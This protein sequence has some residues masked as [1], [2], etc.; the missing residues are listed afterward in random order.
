MKN[1]IRNTALSLA[2]A[3]VCAVPVMAITANNTAT[4]NTITAS[5]EATFHEQVIAGI[6]YKCFNDD[7]AFV[8][9][10]DTDL[11]IAR[12]PQ[13]IYDGSRFYWVE[14]ISAYAFK[15][16]KALTAIDLSHAA[17]LTTIQAGAFKGASNLRSVTL[18]PAVTS[19]EYEAFMDCSS[20]ESFDLNGSSLPYI[21][22]R[23]FKGCSSLSQFDLPGSVSFIGPEAFAESGI[24]EIDVKGN[25]SCIREGAFRNCRQLKKLTIEPSQTPISLRSEAFKD[26]VNL[27]LADLDR[28]DT[29]T[30]IDVFYGCNPRTLP[31]DGLIM[32]GRGIPSFTRS[33]CEKLLKLWDIHYDPNATDEEKRAVLHELGT[34][35]RAYAVYDNNG[36]RDL[37]CAPTVLSTRIS[38]CGGFTRSFY[39][40]AVTMGFDPDDILIG[41]DGHCHGWN[42]VRFD[43]KW[44]SYDI[45]NNGYY[46]ADK[47]M[48]RN[49]LLR[50]DNYD[51]S[52]EDS[53]LW[54]VDV[55]D[56]YGTINNSEL[57]AEGFHK[58]YTLGLGEFAH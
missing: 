4:S 32:T 26:C 30:A 49:I 25:V 19:V 42:F 14:A 44:Y 54:G 52:H 12:I 34:K 2:L 1:T 56:Y 51:S 27:L 57:G 28:D 50:F 38:I 11:T 13:F 31:G 10:F 8:C 5:A 33:M 47:E 20:L 15:D 53:N 7:T 40:L 35:L 18:S 22:A 36:H 37:N 24:T 21:E 6:H 41:G 46:L 9:G 45:T 48:Y 55:K 3:A 58:F 43:G 17:Y 16:A 23:T 39:N 29:D